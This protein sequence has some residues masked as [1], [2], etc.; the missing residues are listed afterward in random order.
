MADGN[1]SAALA[2]VRKSIAALSLE[3]ALHDLSTPEGMNTLLP[4]LAQVGKDAKS[5]GMPALVAMS[6]ATP[7]TE[8]E[9]LDAISH[10]QQFVATP[11]VNPE[12]KP[13]A[14]P[15]AL[16]Q[17]PE[18]I[19]DFLLESREYL[20][21]VEAQLLVL[22]RNPADME[23]I[24]T[25]FRGF[26]TI[27]GLAGFLE[28][29]RIQK[30]A[31]EV[32][33]LLDLARTSRISV[34]SDLIDLILQSTDFMN[35]CLN[36]VETGHE[37]ASDAGPLIARI[38]SVI[39]GVAASKGDLP[40]AAKLAAPPPPVVAAPPIPAV[41]GAAGRAADLAQLALVV[42]KPVPPDIPA[43]GPPSVLSGTVLKP[44]AVIPAA[45]AVEPSA[46]VLPRCVK[47]DTD[48]LDYL[49]EMVGELV[50]AQS[51]I[52]HDPDLAALHNPKLLRN[53]GHLGRITADVQHVAM[54]MRMIPI[55]QLFGRMARLVRDLA[56][57]S[58]KQADL[59]L[60]GEDTELDRDMVE[61]LADPLMHMMRNSMDHGAEMPDVRIARGKSPVARLELK[62]YHKGGFINIEVSDDGQGLMRDKIL[63]KAKERGMI[64]AG[65]HLSDQE[66]FKFIFEPGFSTAD[67]VTDVSGRGVGMD[68]VRKHVAKLRGRID[69]TSVAG[70][71]TTFVI[72][73][74]LT[75]AIIEGLV[76]GVGEQRYILPI[77]MVKEMFRPTAD[78]LS[79]VPDGGEMVMVRGS[80]LP[81]LRLY[82]RFGVIPTSEDPTESVL[83]VV[84][85]GR[86]NFCV[87]VDQLI[88]K[89]EVVIKSLGETFSNVTGVAGGSILG[90][91]R[92]GLILDVEGLFGNP[93]RK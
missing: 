38:R 60:T 70:K 68:V 92:V 24:N 30:F 9:F 44:A 85:G 62:A 58:G 56:R 27:K 66:I 5:A 41:H 14:P 89:Q 59:V 4:M 45:I 55:R 35:Q 26:H 53:V 21:N 51:L 3:A 69:I 15:E 82:R 10:M 47:V 78:A 31:H 42:A 23:A 76:V 17:D 50:I 79:T 2:S 74:P 39:D 12:A 20:S 43:A 73:L 13:K 67:K 75:M 57:K 16:N 19:S 80:L 32:E 8:K 28:F 91:G 49:V 7:G 71:G 72:K 83:V 29:P 87:Q 61:E 11:A 25:I 1:S 34:Q 65:E 81:I 40:A 77:F 6:S 48:K 22:E 36:G 54:A 52:Q 84:E 64:S 86:K 37:S 46:V 63:A 88:G 93:A 18:L 90:D 33:T